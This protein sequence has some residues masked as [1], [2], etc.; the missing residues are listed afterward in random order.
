MSTPRQDQEGPDESEWL[1]PD[2]LFELILSQ[3]VDQVVQA[4][5]DGFEGMRN[6]ECSLSEI[7]TFRTNINKL[8]ARGH[9]AWKDLGFDDQD[10][11]NLLRQAHAPFN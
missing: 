9:F 3:N 2:F 8:V 1:A 10:L 4:C 5:R 6:G 11:Q 7:E